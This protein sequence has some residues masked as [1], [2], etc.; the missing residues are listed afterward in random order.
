[1]IEHGL[2]EPELVEEGDFFVVKFYGPGDNILD[3]VSSIPDDQM[4][5][6]KELG[7]NDRQIEALKLMVNEGKV[8]TS[9]SYQEIYDVSRNTASRHLNKLIE[10]KQITK[11]GKGR[12]TKYKAV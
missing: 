9:K 1:M 12:Y 6:L 8:F 10:L 7:L 4:T 5:D 3:L 2:E 11:I